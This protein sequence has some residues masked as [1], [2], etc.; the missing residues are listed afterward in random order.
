VG[1]SLL[2]GLLSL[3]P[4]AGVVVGAAALLLAVKALLGKRFGLLPD[5]QVKQQLVLLILTLAA[6]PAVVF[7]LP[8]SESQQGQLL[9]LLGVLGAAAIALSSTTFLGNAMAGLM[10][11]AVGGF[12]LGDFVRVGEHFGRVSERGLFH[13]E[14]QTEDRDLTTLPNLYLV[15][16]PVK[17]VRSSGTIVSSE[18]SL[19]YD[20][21]RED[22]ERLLTEAAA[23]AE[24]QDPFVL[25]IELG[26]FAV[27]YRVAGLLTDVKGVLTA[28]SRL[29]QMVL[30]KLHQGGVE[31]V[32]PTF[33]NTRAIEEGRLFI[34]KR[35]A[36]AR[37][38]PEAVPE[39]V[40]FDKA[41]KAAAAERV[42]KEYESIGKRIEMLSQQA[43]GSI[44]TDQEIKRLAARR[45]ELETLIERYR[46][47][48]DEDGEDGGT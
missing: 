13:L 3:A 18:V 31:I 23:D 19:G 14:I 34:P 15:T 9:G 1:R 8:L 45:A 10:L 42:R 21:P 6:V 17:V 22:V 2:E 36:R 44:Q 39:V 35:Q 20:Q 48:S 46:Q 32:S 11:R 40:I 16:N 4:A 41:E 30:D 33:M 27:T 29:Q 24:L 37:P 43:S 26:D 12:R 38:Q 5:Q 47:E 25:I 28:R 7:A